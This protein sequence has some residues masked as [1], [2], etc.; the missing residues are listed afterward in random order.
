MAKTVY[1][2]TAL[3]GGGITA[4]DGINGALL[5]NNDAAFVN[6][7]DI[8]YLYLLN[9]TIGGVEVIPDKIVPDVGSGTK[10]W[11]LQNLLMTGFTS[12]STTSLLIGTGSK[13]LTIQTNKGFVVG[14]SV[15]IAYTTTPT[16]WMYGVITSYNAT[17]GELIVE[18]ESIQ[19]SGT[20]A[21][22]TISMSAPMQTAAGDIR[23]G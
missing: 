3:V 4:L 11:V 18:V 13:T 19:G 2:K 1:Y 14:M 22:W 20:Y 6:V 5:V 15:K 7:N 12:T 16:K 17:P 10:R 8:A 21:V 23:W 9:S